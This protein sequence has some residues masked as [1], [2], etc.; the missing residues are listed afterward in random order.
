MEPAA[1]EMSSLL[2]RVTMLEEG[3]PLTSLDQ[4]TDRG[5]TEAEISALVISRRALTMRRK[6]GFPLS[7]GEGDRLNRLIRVI[8]VA[9]NVFANHEKAMRWLRRENDRL[10]GRSPLS[11][12][13]YE[14]G[15][16]AA[17]EMLHQIDEG[18]YV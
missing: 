5:L 2:K 17:I 10:N 16:E 11:L 7:A 3:L 13:R 15:A 14:V 6:K 4:L 18:V 9:D 1:N 12:L 8:D